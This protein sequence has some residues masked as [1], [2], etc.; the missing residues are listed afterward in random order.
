[1]SVEN[2][3]DGREVV[4]TRDIP[5]G[6]LMDV[7]R[8]ALSKH[9]KSLEGGR[10][11]FGNR[12]FRSPD[13]AFVDRS[14]DKVKAALIVSPEGDKFIKTYEGILRD[15]EKALK[16]SGTL[17]EEVNRRDVDRFLLDRK[18][19]NTL[20]IAGPSLLSS[21]YSFGVGKARAVIDRVT[22]ENT[23]IAVTDNA[24]LFYLGEGA[25]SRVYV[26]EIDKAKY[27][28][29]ER[30][31][32]NDKYSNVEDLT[33]PYMNEMLQIQEM[34]AELGPLL[35]KYN[36]T[37]PEHLFASGSVSCVRFEEGDEAREDI[38]LRL[39]NEKLF[40]KVQDFVREK[41]KM[42]PLWENVRVDFISDDHLRTQ[43]FIKRPDGTLAW[44]DPLY[45]V[46]HSETPA[47]REKRLKV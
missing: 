34:K 39:Y 6:E 12:I 16:H 18:V 21:V 36:V 19:T 35:A 32:K 3:F 7:D 43:N 45:F 38:L 23:Y 5:G 22:R 2:S 17:R 28:V 10:D 8:D 46:D 26:L 13:L 9:Y 1:M 4:N 24:R 40:F 37:L 20:E 29:K 31:N 25:Q 33:Q 44:I 27:I 11:R 15:L 30:N 47:Q 14:H 41:A 42:S